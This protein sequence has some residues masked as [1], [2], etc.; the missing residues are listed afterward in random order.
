MKARFG[1]EIV[2][3]VCLKDDEIIIEWTGRFRYRYWCERCNRKVTEK[4]Y[5]GKDIPVQ[6]TIYGG[7]V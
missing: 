2:C 4:D 6:K 3:Q 1:R 5:T 7:S